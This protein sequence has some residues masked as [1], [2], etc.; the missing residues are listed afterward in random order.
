MPTLFSCFCYNICVCS[1]HDCTFNK[2]VKIVFHCRIVSCFPPNNSRESSRVQYAKSTVKPFDSIAADAA[3]TGFFTWILIITA[4]PL[5]WSAVI[6]GLAGL[7]PKHFRLQYA[8]IFD[9]LTGTSHAL[10]LGPIFNT[11]MKVLNVVLAAVA[12]FSAFLA[13]VCWAVAR[14]KVRC[15]VEV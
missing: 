6:I 7:V 2:L 1:I 10:E 9:V 14:G 15:D 12:S 11:G 8:A 13:W 3:A 5:V 4:F